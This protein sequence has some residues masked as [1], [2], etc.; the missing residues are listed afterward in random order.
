MMGGTDVEQQQQYVGSAKV[1]NMDLFISIS[2]GVEPLLDTAEVGG[3]DMNWLHFCCWSKFS[4]D[5][6]F[7]TFFV[8]I[9][10]LVHFNFSY[11]VPGLGGHIYFFPSG[12]NFYFTFFPY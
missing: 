8:I 6:N 1:Q 4:R 9:W 12:P 5:W 3:I 10:S 7:T 11:T 2:Q